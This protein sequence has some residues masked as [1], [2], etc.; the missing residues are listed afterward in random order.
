MGACRA[1][2]LAR[3]THPK[4]YNSETYSPRTTVVRRPSNS[5]VEAGYMPE[6][7]ARAGPYPKPPFAALQAARIVATDWRSASE[8]HTVAPSLEPAGATS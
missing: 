2:S 6:A 1:S 4:C 5:P 3:S 8:R 7:L